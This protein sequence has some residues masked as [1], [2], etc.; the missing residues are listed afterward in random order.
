M[1]K[2]KISARAFSKDGFII[3][4]QLLKE[5]PYG[6]KHSDYNG[7]GWIAAYNFL[8]AC[9][10]KKDYDLVRE[11]LEDQLILG[12]LLGTHLLQL[13][14]YLRR[15]GFHLHCAL[16]QKAAQSY[17]ESCRA[18]I[19]FYFNGAA[20]HFVA[21][22]PAPDYVEKQE[23]QPAALAEDGMVTEMTKKVWYRFFN[24]RIGRQF[25][26]DT[27]ENFLEKESQTAILVQ[28]TTQSV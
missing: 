9:G 8:H 10:R 19:L 7:C 21:F 20:F 2:C 12:G 24:G 3:N 6:M 23:D 13:Y 17:A 4:Q 26:Y 22:V 15:H 1:E 25:D 16:G 11:Q 14:L 28:I 27:M 18:G 5:L